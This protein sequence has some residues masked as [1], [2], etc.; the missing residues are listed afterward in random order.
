MSSFKAFDFI[1][2]F[3]KYDRNANPKFNQMKTV[4]CGFK[5]GVVFTLVILLQNIAFASAF[6][7]SSELKAIEQDQ[8]SAQKVQVLLNQI[9]ARRIDLSKPIEFNALLMAI[10]Q[11]QDSITVRRKKNKEGKL[12]IIAIRSETAYIKNVQLYSDSLYRYVEDAEI[13]NEKLIKFSRNLFIDN[14]EFEYPVKDLK[15]NQFTDNKDIG[16]DFII[17]GW[18]F[19][20]GVTIGK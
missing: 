7:S 10:E 3:Y 5:I 20:K 2:A 6:H 19:R 9:Q 4:F 11:I 13:V 8:S 18:S 12:P 15:S 1:P 14:I 16:E 17:T